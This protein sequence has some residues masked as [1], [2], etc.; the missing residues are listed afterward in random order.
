[1]E[2]ID[3]L[4]I[5]GGL[6][7]LGVAAALPATESNLLIEKKSRLLGH[8]QSHSANGV[9]FDEGVHV[10]HSKNPEWLALLN[11]DA[12]N[13]IEQ[14]V[15][16]NYDNG[17][18][19]DYPVQNNLRQIPR[20]LAVRALEE[21]EQAYTGQQA[22]VENYDEWLVSVYG[23]AL[24]E[25]YYR[26]FTRKY[27][28]TET[29]DL[30]LDWLAGRLLP[31]DISLVRRGIDKGSESQAVFNSYLYPS[32]GGFEALFPKL[33]DNAIANTSV[34]FNTSVRGIDANNR[35]VD[36]SNGKRYRFGKLFSSLPIVELPDIDASLPHEL[37]L[38]I[39]KLRHTRLFTVCIK[40]SGVNSKDLADWFYVYDRG[41]DV[42][43]VFNA[44][45]A[46]GVVDS[47][48]LA[49]ET[50]RRSD[51]EYECASV[52]SSVLSSMRS[53]FPDSEIEVI[54]EF[55]TEYAYIVPLD[56]NREV[57]SEAQKYYNDKEIY[58]TGVY[59]QWHYTWSDQTYFGARELAQKVYEAR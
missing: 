56:V 1:M 58:L 45:K 47:C 5:G 34:V 50:Y 6:A 16:R 18:W 59:G 17:D 54:K 7:G 31:V 21:I 4:I 24:T 35:I 55:M 30:G 29:S 57:I 8:A 40:V 38:K 28:R 43:R 25:R 53:I 19:I 32:T 14:S 51:E 39:K 49:C 41:L 13:N 26:R 23:E 22:A 48:F 15:V 46:S 27:W 10:C 42:S 36:A 33:I 9:Y 37:A 12:A 2:Y 11:L 3:N 44:S 20:G 52:Y